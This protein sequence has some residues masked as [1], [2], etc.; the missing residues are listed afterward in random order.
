[1]PKD[2]TVTS[3]KAKRPKPFDWEKEYLE[4]MDGAWEEARDSDIPQ[5]KE[6]DGQ[7]N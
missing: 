4:M 2:M 6:D 3:K 5:E 7:D 1:M